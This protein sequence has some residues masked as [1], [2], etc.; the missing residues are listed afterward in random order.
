MP[1]LRAV[2]V[3]KARNERLKFIHFEGTAEDCSERGGREGLVCCHGNS[4]RS[5]K[6][7]NMA[8]IATTSSQRV[9]VFVRAR[10][11]PYFASEFINTR[12][13]VGAFLILL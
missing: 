11:T 13:K 9:K 10:P 12:D 8:T 5:T 3:L 2:A 4:R 7:Q 1:L 6:L